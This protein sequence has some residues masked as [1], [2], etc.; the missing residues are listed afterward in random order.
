MASHYS[1][2]FL[3]PKLAKPDGTRPLRTTIDYRLLN[4]CTKPISW[5]LPNIAQMLQRIGRAK[6]RYYA[7]LDMTGGYWQTPISEAC[8]KFTAFI[9]F[10]GI[11][12]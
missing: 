6:P 8:K 3:V 4:A 2:V 10:M 11:F 7:K 12:E 5:P 1:Q 9:T